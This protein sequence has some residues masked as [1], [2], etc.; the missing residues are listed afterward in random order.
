MAIFDILLLNDKHVISK[1]RNTVRA[2]KL[3]RAPVLTWTDNTSKVAYSVNICRGP[4]F[5]RHSSTPLIDSWYI[6]MWHLLYI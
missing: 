3:I 1:E 4:R 6:R 2:S 5:Q